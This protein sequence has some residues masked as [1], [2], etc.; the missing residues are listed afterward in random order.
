LASGR[1]SREEIVRRQLGVATQLFIDDLDPVSIH[2]LVSSAAENASLL[3]KNTSCPTFNDHIQATFPEKSLKDIHK[4]RNQF[5]T[6]IKH[7]RDKSGAPF[8]FPDALEGFDDQT[9]DHTLFVVWHDYSNAGF[10]L[11]LE[12]QLFQVWYFGLYPEKLRDDKG[13]ISSRKI[14]GHLAGLTRSEQKSRLRQV[15]AKCRGDEEISKNPKTDTRPL[16][17]P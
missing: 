9:N 6:P 12:T 8:E 3:A 10:P 5:W 7:S 1:Y 13:A 2:C 4:L 11:P 15:I 17:L 16:V 14:F